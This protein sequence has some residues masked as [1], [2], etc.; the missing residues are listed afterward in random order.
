MVPVNRTKRERERE[1]ERERGGGREGERDFKSPFYAYLFTVV[2]FFLFNYCRSLGWFSFYDTCD[3]L[4][5]EVITG[6][7]AT[8]PCLP[9]AGLASS[10]CLDLLLHQYTFNP[11]SGH[12]W[13]YYSISIDLT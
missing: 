11:G 9:F 6:C 4:F 3:F 13:T 10:R 12:V 2:L 5:Y 1:R 8:K 7:V